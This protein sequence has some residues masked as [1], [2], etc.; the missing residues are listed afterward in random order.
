MPVSVHRKPFNTLRPVP[1]GTSPYGETDPSS[2]RV[3]SRK[4]LHLNVIISY[5][6]R[7]SDQ[8]P[9][10]PSNISARNEAR[11]VEAMNMRSTSARLTGMAHSD[12]NPGSE[13]MG[14]TDGCVAIY[15]DRTVPSCSLLRRGTAKYVHDRATSRYGKRTSLLITTTARTTRT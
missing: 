4:A 7:S 6:R 1:R 12:R 2:C 10:Y 9:T 14:R 8:P 15:L 13:G 3:I 5:T 11:S